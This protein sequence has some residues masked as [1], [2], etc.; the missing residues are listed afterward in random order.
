MQ[1]WT[2]ERVKPSPIIKRDE[3]EDQS[4]HGVVWPSGG[5]LDEEVVAVCDDDE[6]D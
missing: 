2:L 1:D 3:T 5:V 6:E 4:V